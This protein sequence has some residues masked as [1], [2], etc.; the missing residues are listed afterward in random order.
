MSKFAL[1]GSH[2]C[3]IYDNGG[4]TEDIVESLKIDGSIEKFPD[5]VDPE[6]LLDKTSGWNQYS[7][8]SEEEYLEITTALHEVNS[9]NT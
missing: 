6:W 7:F 9:N 5:V 2:V 3:I 8:I 4:T 1:F